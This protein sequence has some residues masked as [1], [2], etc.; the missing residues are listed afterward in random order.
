[1]HRALRVSP[2]KQLSFSR[3]IDK[4]DVQDVLLNVNDDVNKHWF[5]FGILQ[6][7]GRMDVNPT[8]VF[9][10]VA[11]LYKVKWGALGLQNCFL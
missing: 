9:I 10:A 2:V 1:M 3:S 6:L 11:R 7:I 4:C 8:L 5:E